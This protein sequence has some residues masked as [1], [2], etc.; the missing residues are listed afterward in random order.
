VSGARAWAVAGLLAVGCTTP[1]K[2]PCA[3]GGEAGAR[4]NVPL[5]ERYS[6]RSTRAQFREGQVNAGLASCGNHDGLGEGQQ[7]AI[8]LGEE[9][10]GNALGQSGCYI[11]PGETASPPGWSFTGVG[12]VSTLRSNMV[13]V[14]ARLAR[15]QSC[16]GQW[17]VSLEAT[18]DAMS[19][20]SPERPPPLLVR[21]N[22]VTE[23]AEDC[24]ALAGKTGLVECEDVWISWLRR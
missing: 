23:R 17:I 16:S 18:G 7:L 6:A 13:T 3:P 21:R 8:T 9:K 24:P 15:N 20:P 19:E 2:D 5:I 1:F 10:L 12:S 14:I 11:H 4:Y 22:F